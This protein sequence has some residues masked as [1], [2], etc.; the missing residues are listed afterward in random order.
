V[1]AGELTTPE[2][3]VVLYWQAFK[4]MECDTNKLQVMMNKEIPPFIIMRIARQMAE[5]LVH[6]HARKI[7]HRDIKPHNILCTWPK[8]ESLR[9]LWQLL[10]NFA[11]TDAQLAIEN[12]RA[13]IPSPTN[14]VM[15]TLQ[16]MS[17]EQIRNARSVTVNSDMWSLGVTLYELATGGDFPHP[18]ITSI[19]ELPTILRERPRLFSDHPNAINY[20][21]F[22]QKLMDGMLDMDQTRRPSSFELLRALLMQDARMS[23]AFDQGP[24]LLPDRVPVTPP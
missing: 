7:V 3:M 19:K 24:M 21:P 4:K 17:P 18:P 1:D 5:V 20:P 2:G 6:Y 13:I 15:G 10:I 23:L 11:L 9:E 14:M 12:D 16:Y 8:H 22:F